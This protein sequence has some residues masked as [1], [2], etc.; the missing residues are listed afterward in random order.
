[1]IN[2]KKKNLHKKE[3]LFSLLTKPVEHKVSSFNPPRLFL[4]QL[5]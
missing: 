5:S 2:Y 3:T 4:I 1:M